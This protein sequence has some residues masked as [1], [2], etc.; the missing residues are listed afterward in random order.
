MDDL[1]SDVLA[2][3][4]DKLLLDFYDSLHFIDNL[5]FEMSAKLYF[6]NPLIEFD[7][8]SEYWIDAKVDL[9][10]VEPSTAPWKRIWKCKLRYVI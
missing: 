1:E 8:K 9:G 4:Y 2:L 7:N 5:L 10:D 3:E 6:D